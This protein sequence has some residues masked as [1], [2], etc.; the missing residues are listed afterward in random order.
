VLGASSAD[1]GGGGGGSPTQGGATSTSTVVIGAG[2]ILKPTAW[3]ILIWTFAA[4]VMVQ[5][6]GWI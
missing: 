1:G 2:G 3:S 4:V 5:V 6:C